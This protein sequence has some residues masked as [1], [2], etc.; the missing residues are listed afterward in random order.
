V[1]LAGRRISSDDDFYAAVSAAASP[2]SVVVERSGEERP[3]RLEV[4]LDG[5]PQRWGIGWRVDEAEPGVVILTSIVPGSPAARAGLLVGDRIYQVAGRD[6]ADSPQFA[7][8]ANTLADSL[9]LLVERS[10]R[11]RTVTIRFRQAEPGKLAA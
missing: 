11:L 7:L 1:R 10:G 3:L 4:T 8:L 9:Q 5:K 2:A 6:F